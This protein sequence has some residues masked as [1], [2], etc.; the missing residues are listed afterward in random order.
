MWTHATARH[1]M[2][3]MDLKDALGG[4]GQAQTPCPPIPAAGLHVDDPAGRKAGQTGVEAGAARGR[5]LFRG[6][7]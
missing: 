6:G 4:Q 3:R 1:A 2:T 5:V 7:R